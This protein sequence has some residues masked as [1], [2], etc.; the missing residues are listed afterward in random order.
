[1]RRGAGPL[2][3]AEAHTPDASAKK[4]SP[5]LILGLSDPPKAP[6]GSAQGR[7]RVAPRMWRHEW[8][9]FTSHSMK[10]PEDRGRVTCFHIL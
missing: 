1:M 5:V 10:V 7:V 2:A 6:A 8:H 9:H 3:P 4:E